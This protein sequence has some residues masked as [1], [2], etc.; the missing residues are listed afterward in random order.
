MREGLAELLGLPEGYE[1]L[2]G[3]GGTTALWD[4]LAFGIVRERAL[5]LTYGEF[6]SKFAKV[7]AGAPFLADPGGH[8]GRA[9]HRAGAGRRRL[10]DVVAW[11]HNETSTGVM[12]RVERPAG[13]ALVLVDATSGAGGLPLDAPQADVYYFAP[14]KSF[15]ADGGIWLAA[16]SPA[17]IER[18]ERDRRR[19][20]A[21]SP[22]SCR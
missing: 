15:A 19:R 21:G 18:I 4:A 10:V 5:H 6:S 12:L 17:A 11:A 14:Q 9:R 1:V 13:D 7:T 20:I 2:L 16:M 22:T 8:R 3:N